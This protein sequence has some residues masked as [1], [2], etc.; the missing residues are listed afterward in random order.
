M[1]LQSAPHG[2]GAAALCNALEAVG[3]RLTQ[4][5]A[6]KLCKTDA[7]GTSSV[8]IKKALRVLGYA[9]EE[10]ET[11]NRMAAWALVCGYLLMGYPCL[12]CVDHQDHWVVGI[13]LLG[14]LIVIVDSADGGITS[15]WSR[16][17]F[18]DRLSSGGKRPTYSGIAVQVRESQ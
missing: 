6:A 8:D 1:Q 3:Y 18:L 15:T 2:C 9:P 4:D 7:D 5:A 13:G 10:W 17:T 16:K 14:G 11:P 12:L